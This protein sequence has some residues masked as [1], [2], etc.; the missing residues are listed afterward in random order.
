MDARVPA[1]QEKVEPAPQS[2]PGH[3]TMRCPFISTDVVRSTGAR[4][5]SQTAASAAA[6]RF[7]LPLFD[8][9]MDVVTIPAVT[10]DPVPW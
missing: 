9:S 7:A 6:D 4:Q 1:A 5:V 3:P 10:A 2:Q 8:A